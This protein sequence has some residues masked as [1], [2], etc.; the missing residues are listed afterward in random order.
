MHYAEFK[1][2]DPALVREMVETFP[3]ATIIVN[4]SDG[5]VTAQAPITFRKGSGAAGAV[6]FH[7]AA[8]NLITPLLASGAPITIMVH[9]P[10]AHI[11]PAWFTASFPVPSSER[12]RTAPTYNYVSLVLGGR[13]EHRDDQALQ[14]QIGDL[15]LAYE[16]PEG[17]RLDELA[18]DLWEGWRSAIRLY[19]IEISR[20]D[21]TAKLSL[22]DIAE[23]RPGVVDGLRRRGIQDDHAMAML[24]D[25]FAEGSASLTAGLHA[26]R[27]PLR[28]TGI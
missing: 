26:L 14:D 6:E 27:A 28:S 18:P 5:P 8:A 22:G 10:G 13:L 15:V 2:S 16:G 21:L 4:G 23:D 7:L 17:W 9:G 19:R 20:F 12:N 1:H 3:F 24:V 25:G 11:S